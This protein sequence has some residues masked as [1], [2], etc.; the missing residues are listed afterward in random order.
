MKG[1]VTDGDAGELFLLDAAGPGKKLGGPTEHTR[2]VQYVKAIKVMVTY[3]YGE[4][5]LSNVAGPG[6][7]LNGPT[8]RKKG[9]AVCESDEGP[10]H[11]RMCW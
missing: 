9:R 6:K 10:C 8:K 7:M 11:L 2:G 4:P 5:F 1:L 3:G